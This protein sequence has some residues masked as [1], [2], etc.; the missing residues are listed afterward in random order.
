MP[1]PSSQE[2]FRVL[3]TACFLVLGAADIPPDPRLK[4]YVAPDGVKVEVVAEAPVVVN[5]VGLAFAD[6]GT[7]FVLERGRGKDVVKA[8]TS[9]KDGTFDAG[10]VVVEDD[11]VAAIL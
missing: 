1:L 4:G 5:P 6:D 10:K 9:G 3:L 11:R 7:P 2:D 8:L